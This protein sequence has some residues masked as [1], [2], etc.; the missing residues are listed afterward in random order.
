MVKSFFVNQYHGFLRPSRIY[1]FLHYSSI[2]STSINFT[3]DLV[4]EPLSKLLARFC[5]RKGNFVR[6]NALALIIG[7]LDT[8]SQL[9]GPPATLHFSL[10]ISSSRTSKKTI[11]NPTAI[12]AA[13]ERMVNISAA[14]CWKSL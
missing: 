7:K 10:R 11:P 8:L 4:Y 1:D 9:T 14:R 2:C 6:E 3:F 5:H 13:D 12:V